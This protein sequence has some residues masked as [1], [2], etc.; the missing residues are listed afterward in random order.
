M[1]STKRF[2]TAI[3]KKNDVVAFINGTGTHK[4]EFHGIPP[5]N[6]LVSVRTADLYK[7]KDRII[8]GCWIVVDQ[9]NLLKQLG[10]LVPE[11]VNK[12]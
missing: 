1:I 6:K 3:S 8:T 5:T 10:T 11:D 12:N 2:L 9:L 7:I 4:C